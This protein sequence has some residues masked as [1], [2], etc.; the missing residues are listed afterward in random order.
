VKSTLLALAL[1]LAAAPAHA[2]TGTSRAEA[3]RDSIT[4]NAVM[5]ATT[6]LGAE[7]QSHPDS[8]DREGYRLTMLVSRVA[9][10]AS[11]Q[12][13]GPATLDEF[14]PPV[15]EV[16]WLSTCDVWGHRVRF[17][18]SEREF[19]VRSA[20]RD[21]IFDTADDLLQSGLVPRIQPRS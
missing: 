17:T 19:E 15:A 14:A 11:E 7:R 8:V 3:C 18:R 5:S 16:P 6:M 20:G 13:R 9:G 4:G 1:L 21:G 10:F 12:R 2:Q